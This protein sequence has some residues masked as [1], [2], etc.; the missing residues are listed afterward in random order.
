MSND[1]YQQQNYWTSTPSVTW[2]QE[3]EKITLLKI[4][5]DLEKFFVSTSPCPT[6]LKFIKNDKTI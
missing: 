5:Q 1:E 4:N 2:V 6:K 3:Q